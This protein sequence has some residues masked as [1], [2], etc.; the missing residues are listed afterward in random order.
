LCF[1][2]FFFFLIFFG[3]GGGG[4]GIFF[5]LWGGG[6]VVVIYLFNTGG[7]RLHPIIDL[8]I[9]N[10]CNECKKWDT[11]TQREMIGWE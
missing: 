3:G 1:F 4:G 6:G 9:V 10:L 11:R 8:L 2:F 5:F 7:Q